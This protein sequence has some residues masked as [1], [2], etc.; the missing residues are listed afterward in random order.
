MKNRQNKTVSVEKP[1]KKKLTK[2][3]LREKNLTLVLILGVS[4]LLLGGFILATT[5]WGT[6]N[7]FI[8]MLAIL[9][10]SIVFSL[11]SYVARKLQIRQT[12]FAFT[13]L[14]ALFLP[15]VIVC[16]S[17][18]HLLGSYFA[19]HGY[20]AS[21]LGCLSSLLF[22]LLYNWIA[23]RYS[24]RLFEGLSLLFGYTA[25]CFGAYF[26][27]HQQRTRRTPLADCSSTAKKSIA[28]IY[29][30]RFALCGV[31]RR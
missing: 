8:K 28:S 12:A 3:Q 2:E 21:L 4:F 27:T 16:A 7:T 6:M 22:V 11:M 19:L 30:S 31:A 26:L 25:L 14:S 17:Y 9:S 5:N 20:G 24:S 29:Q 15:I 13:T 10:V 1:S 23:R 18:Y